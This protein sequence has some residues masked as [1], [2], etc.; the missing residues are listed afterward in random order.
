VADT[1]IVST[2]DANMV[3][4]PLWM[5][6]V[7]P[8]PTFSF[9]SGDDRQL[10]DALFPTQGV[11]GSAALKVSQRGA[12]A[13]FSVD[14]AVGRAAIK[15]DD[16]ANQGS[17]VVQ[18]NGIVN[19]TTPG[20]PVSGTRV[21]RL[22]ARI[23]DKQALG[24][25]TYDWTLHLME[26]TGSGTP[27]EPNSAITL[28]LISIATGQASVL[29]ANITD[30]RAQAQ[31]FNSTGLIADVTLGAAATTVTFASIP[32][33]FRHLMVVANTRSDAALS[34]AELKVR[35]NNDSA[36]HYSSATL[37]LNTA[38]AVSGTSDN[39]QT[40]ITYGAIIAGGNLS[41]GITAGAVFWLP[42]YAGS[43]WL[44]KQCLS[45][46][47]HADLGTAH[48]LRVRTGVWVPTSVTPI[49]RLD[50]ICS[51]GNFVAGSYFGVYG[52]GI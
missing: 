12:G 43:T 39:A 3:D 35:M 5:Q 4:Y 52:L 32:A 31:A 49:S 15:G 47:A 2:A 37:D 6:A 50:F 46:S 40:A 10:I 38:N 51:S 34:S 48:N 24:S 42:E 21:H 18:T 13:N 45:L 8:D 9:A 26:D 33:T 17:Y 14:V 19:V 23:R 16:A 25:G 22:V 1:I 28:A 20:A 7:N 36:A 29:N 27:A 30:Q 11:L 44:V 41:A